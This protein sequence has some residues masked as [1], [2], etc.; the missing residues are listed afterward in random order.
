V[1]VLRGDIKVTAS[2]MERKFVARLRKERLPLPETNVRA[3]GRHV[4]CRW[5]DFKLTVELDSY[6]YDGSRHA[7]EQDRRRERQ[8]RARGDDFR[9]YTYRD[10]YEEP[11]A[12]IAELRSFFAERPGFTTHGVV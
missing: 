2:A 1:W 11:A 5:P 8:A 4:D 10:V 12:M 9:H 7:W 6:R 3:G